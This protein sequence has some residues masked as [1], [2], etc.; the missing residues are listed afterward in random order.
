MAQFKLT[1]RG[2]PSKAP[3]LGI[4]EGDTWDLAV[5]AYLATNPQAGLSAE[6]I[7]ADPIPDP[8]LMATVRRYAAD[9][10]AAQSVGLDDRQRPA[11]LIEASSMD[12]ALLLTLDGVIVGMF[13]LRDRDTGKGSGVLFGLTTWRQAS[14][15]ALL[16]CCSSENLAGEPESYFGGGRFVPPSERRELTRTM[17]II[18]G[19]TVALE[20]ARPSLERIAGRV[21]TLEEC[22]ARG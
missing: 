22:S 19:L 10:R 1:R 20:R 8:E 4:W 12:T 11:R 6:D 15:F 21:D 14:A 5:E 3:S 17:T 7:V 2:A 16:V 18:D 13:D 9:I